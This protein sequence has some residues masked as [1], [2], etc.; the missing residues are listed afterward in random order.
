VKEDSNDQETQVRQLPIIFSEEE[1]EDREA[2]KFG[3]IQDAR[4][5]QE[6]RK[7][8]AVL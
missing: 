8:R 2:T 5:G 6:T 3:H 7:G 4:C 1:S